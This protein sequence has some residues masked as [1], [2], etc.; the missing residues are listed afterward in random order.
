MN[1]SLYRLS[2]ARDLFGSFQIDQFISEVNPLFCTTSSV[3]EKFGHPPNLQ[4]LMDLPTFNPIYVSMTRYLGHFFRETLG[5]S[6]CTDR[7][8]HGLII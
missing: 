8:I 4:E 7:A 3:L 2:G 5:R 6:A 1:R